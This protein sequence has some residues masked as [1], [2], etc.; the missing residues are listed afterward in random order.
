QGIVALDGETLTECVRAYFEQSEQI[1]TAF[2]THVGR[3]GENQWTGGSIML[4]Q[5]AREG[6]VADPA[7]SD[8]HED[9]WRRAMLLMQTI[10]ATEMLDAE[11]PLNTL[12]YRVFHEE[13][14]RVFEPLDIRKGCRCSAEKIKPVLDGLSEDERRDIAKD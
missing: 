10:A 8:T 14:I 5:L 2:I 13:G 7:P 1:R 3:N 12:L 4:Q 11:L 6:G 9:E